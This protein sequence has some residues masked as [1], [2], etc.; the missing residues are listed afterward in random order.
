[1]PADFKVRH[2]ALATK[3]VNTS[4]ICRPVCCLW[5][6]EDRSGQKFNP[7]VS[8]QKLWLPPHSC[9]WTLALNTSWFNLMSPAFWSLAP[10]KHHRYTELDC[11]AEKYYLPPLKMIKGCEGG[12][13]SASCAITASLWNS[14]SFI[15]SLKNNSNQRVLFVGEVAANL[16]LNQW[17]LEDIALA[18]HCCASHR[19]FWLKKKKRDAREVRGVVRWKWRKRQTGTEKERTTESVF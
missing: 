19:C 9:Q 1:M 12:L 7:C 8:L 2:P 10:S 18:S 16:P 14:L 5:S 11:L 6:M 15:W 17:F 3:P 4:W 13:S